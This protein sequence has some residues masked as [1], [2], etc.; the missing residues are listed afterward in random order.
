MCGMSWVIGGGSRLGV[1]TVRGNAMVSRVATG[2]AL[3]V[4]GV[5]KLPSGRAGGVAITVGM[6]SGRLNEGSVLGVRGERLSR[7]RLGR[8]T[9][10]TPRTAVGVVESFGPVGGGGVMLPGG[11]ASVVGYAGPGYVAGCRGRPV[12]P[13]FGMIARGPPMIEYRC[14]RGLVGARS[15]CGRFRWSS[16][17]GFLGGLLVF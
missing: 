13:V 15:V 1:G 14:Y 4:L 11:V 6:S 16:F 3:R 9:L 2:G 5:L 12:A 8:I 17:S 10:V 7:R